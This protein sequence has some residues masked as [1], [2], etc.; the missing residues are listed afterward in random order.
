MLNL[1]EEP[2][3]TLDNLGFD[4]AFAASFAQYASDDYRPGRISLEQRSYY[5]VYTEYGEIPAFPTGRMYYDA[6]G[7]Q[8]LPVVGDWVV[9][10]VMDEQPLKG[11][12]H[13]ILPRRSKFS[14]KEAGKKIAEQ[15]IAANIDTVFVV[16][17]LDH[18]FST[19]RVE[20]YLTVAWESGAQ[21]VVLLTKADLCADVAH[22]TA[23]V[24]ASAPGVAVHALSV[25]E[26]QGLEQLSQYMTVG[27]TTAL[28]GSSGVGKSTIINHLLGKE[29]QRIQEVRDLDGKG[30]HTTTHRQMF[31]LSSGA[32]VIDTPGMRELQLWDVGDGLA[33]AFGDVEALAEMCQFR[34]CRHENE[35]G[36]MVRKALDDGDLDPARFGNYLKMEKELLFLERKRNTDAA[37][38]EQAKWKK[39]HK[40]I[41]Q[42]YK[43]R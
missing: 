13:E 32:M 30:R 12:I 18:N 35:P 21:P 1:T 33:G 23:E 3:V 27:K 41:K 22:A 36:C 40:Q 10:R 9:L 16:I 31:V 5:A 24:M 37:R 28:L 8:D 43:N 15:P 39:I 7:Q 29:T 2:E 11:I 34:D 42:Y 19:R 26:S 20:R 17:G 4:S 6:V 25:L 38:T 14:R